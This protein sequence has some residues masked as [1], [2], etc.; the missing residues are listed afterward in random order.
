MWLCVFSQF[1]SSRERE[2]AV[3]SYSICVVCS[4]RSDEKQVIKEQNNSPEEQEFEKTHTIHMPLY[5]A[6]FSNHE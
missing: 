4:C 5:E 2:Y 3:S 6:T 1:E